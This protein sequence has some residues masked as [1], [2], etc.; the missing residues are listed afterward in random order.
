[1][2]K[3][4]TQQEA[5]LERLINRKI[6]KINVLE[7]KIADEAAEEEEKRRLA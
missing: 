1:M 5:N 2:I 3:D 6:Y 7:K 4:F